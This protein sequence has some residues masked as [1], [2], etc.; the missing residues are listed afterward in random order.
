LA[1]FSEAGGGW[2]TIRALF[3]ALILA[4]A[5]G[6][7]RADMQLDQATKTYLEGVWLIDRKP[8]RG[9]CMSGRY[10]ESQVEFEFRKTGGRTVHFDPPDLFGSSKIESARR[11]GNVVT[12]KFLAPEGGEPV[13][14]RLTLGKDSFSVVYIDRNKDAK[15]TVSEPQTAYR[16]GD[17]DW[18]VTADV[19]SEMLQVLTP[20]AVRPGPWAHPAFIELD[21]GLSDANQCTRTERDRRMLLFEVFGPVHYF[22]FGFGFNARFNLPQIR[23]I[24]KVD[25]RTLALDI[26]RQNRETLTIELDAPRIR[27]RELDATFVRCDRRTGKVFE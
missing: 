19:P 21:P 23:Q 6:T 22:V 1:I 3:L 8:D 7:A 27:I 16:C 14:W 11:H 18:S 26:G 20:L 4:C 13:E 25:D 17:P 2:M 12:L 10:N 9:P 24:R 5:T 15:P